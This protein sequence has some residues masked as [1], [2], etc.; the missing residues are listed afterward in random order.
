MRGHG[1]GSQASSGDE[2]PLALLRHLPVGVYRTSVEGAFVDANPALAELLGYRSVEELLAQRVPDLY[3]DP[4]DRERL[5]ARVA[6]EGMVRGFATRVR[7]RD[8][9]EVD[10]EITARAV[11]DEAG[12][13]RFLEGAVVDVSDRVEAERRLAEREELLSAIVDAEPDLVELVGPGGVLLQINRAGLAMI[14]VDSPDEVL[15]RP[16]YPLVAPEHREGFRRLIEEVLAGGSGSFE[17]RIVG[18]RGTTRWLEST[19]VPLRGSDGRVRAALAIA[20]DVTERRQAEE[21]LRSAERRYRTLIE[22]IPA[23]TYVD[24]AD[25]SGT[26]LFVSPQIEQVFGVTQDEWVSSDVSLWVDMIH[27]E[28]RDRVLAAY[29]RALERREPFHAEYRIL[30]RDDRVRWIRDRGEFIPGG[31]G[32]PD[33]LQGVMFDVTADRE[34]EEELRRSREEVRE[35]L[36]RLV[37]AQEEERARIAADIHDDSIQVMTAVGMRVEAARRRASSPE[38]AASLAKLE[39]T[40]AAAIRR[41]RRLLFELRPRALDEEGLAAALR[42]QF[43]RLGEEWDIEWR[44]E[45]G[46]AAEPAPELRTVLFRIAQEALANVRKHSRARRVWV[47]LAEREGGVV[48][49]VR[50]DGVGFRIRDVRAP[51][52][53]HLGLPSMRERAE[54]AGGWLRIDSAPGAGT[55]VEAWV[56]LRAEGDGSKGG[57]HPPIG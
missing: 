44:V 24:L 25:P 17:F 10:V 53:G 49:R 50:D 26:T 41:L 36:S 52:A 56:P 15:G 48:L 20:R 54:M 8:G 29:H 32:G 55:T 12:A 5:L 22:Q 13:L 30:A 40:V 38:E 4:T 7:R 23:V 43:H 19:A 37:R 46:L 51:V 42:E 21:A 11:R 2:L 35:L 3:V 6:R 14:E 39:D 33:L 28:D 9:R 27:P 31:D 16:V 18:L 47:E 57:G 1:T 34:R 45:D